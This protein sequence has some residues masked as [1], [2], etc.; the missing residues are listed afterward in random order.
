[1]SAIKRQ[2]DSTDPIMTFL[3]EIHAIG[4]G[5]RRRS[6]SSRGSNTNEGHAA[7]GHYRY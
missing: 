3:R 5:Q 2:M 4:T 7:A 6:G 1:M